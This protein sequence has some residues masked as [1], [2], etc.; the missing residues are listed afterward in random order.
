M[1][2]KTRI[3]GNSKRTADVSKN[4]ELFVT[5][6]FSSAEKIT[7]VSDN[8]AITIVKPR[9]GERMI[10][11]GLIINTNRDVGVN[12]AVV[13]IYESAA[14]NSTVV[15]KAILSFDVPKSSSVVTSPIL[16]E[17]SA[18]VY[19]NAKADDSEVNVTLLCYFVP[20]VV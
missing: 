9:S 12:G 8:V 2:I 4:S 1:T 19:V 20:E 6:R 18:G 5:Q 16:I 10:I 11:T 13:E 15:S 14:E 17:T 7:L 3:E